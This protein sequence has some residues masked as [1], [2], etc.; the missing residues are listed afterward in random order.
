VPGNPHILTIAFALLA[1]L[2]WGVSDFTGG[3]ASKNTDSVLVTFMAHAGGLVLMTCIAAG[4]Y[5]PLP[6]RPSILWA[7]AAGSLG[8]VGLVLFYHALSSGRMGLAAPLA[9]VLGGAIPALAGI[10]TQGVP[11]PAALVGFVLAGIGIWLI[12]RPDS[13]A[14]DRKGI[15]LAIFAGLGFAGFFLCIH[16]TG[17]ASALWSSAFSRVASVV[18]V[19]AIVLVRNR[20]W[21]LNSRSLLLGVV[22]GCIDS[23]GTYLFVRSDQ[24]G[25]LDSSVVLTSLYPTITVLLAR[26]LLREHF[27]RWKMVGIVAAL[28]AVPLVALQ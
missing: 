21:T 8:G 12:S 17:A 25:R 23:A 28:L 1:S 16:R 15:T 4:T 9:A 22:A 27:T 6:D 19:G 7:M 20:P 24:T 13:S 5:S 18:L 14:T 26:V 11:A 2:S 3:F 10:A